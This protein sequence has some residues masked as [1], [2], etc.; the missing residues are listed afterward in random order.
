MKARLALLAIILAFTIPAPMS[1]LAAQQT[2]CLHGA[3]QSDAQ[4]T[5]TR[6]AL[7]M[8]RQINTYENALFQSAGAYR[9]LRELATLSAPPEGFEVHAAIEPQNYAFTI[10]D[11]IDPCRFA[12]F[13]DSKGTI[14][15]GEALR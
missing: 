5:R 12:Y 10:T 2:A 8:A 9:P 13:S 3:N 7:L 11:T 14:Y 4:R 6:Q 15:A 1:R